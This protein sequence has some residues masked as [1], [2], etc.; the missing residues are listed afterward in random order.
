MANKSN[1]WNRY[2]IWK[3]LGLLVVA[4][5]TPRNWDIHVVDENVGAADYA[6]LPRPDLVGLTAFTSQAP[7]AYELASLF[8]VR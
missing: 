3:P 4:G 7:R 5:L 2:R 1:Y 6:K 8:R